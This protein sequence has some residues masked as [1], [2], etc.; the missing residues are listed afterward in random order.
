MPN[1][2]KLAVC[3]YKNH[4]NNNIQNSINQTGWKVCIDKSVTI[5]TS[6][7]QRAPANQP[8]SIL[9]SPIC[10]GSFCI[11]NKINLHLL[12]STVFFRV[13]KRN[14][15]IDMTKCI[16]KKESYLQWQKTPPLSDL[17][18]QKERDNLLHDKAKL[19]LAS[20]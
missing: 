15:F 6:S 17:Y 14:H 12:R 5:R 2:R 19:A 20:I 11:I 7:L 9:L 18:L 8:Q 16:Q 13:G 10:L 4:S 3:C 1:Y